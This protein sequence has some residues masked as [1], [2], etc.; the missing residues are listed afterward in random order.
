MEKDSF[1]ISKEFFSG[2]IFL[3]ILALFGASPPPLG[4]PHCDDDALPATQP[5]LIALEPRI[6]MGGTGGA[7]GVH[8][9]VRKKGFLQWKEYMKNVKVIFAFCWQNLHAWHPCDAPMPCQTI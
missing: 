1:P 3:K 5:G 4:P 8:N 6:P 2:E 7:R 9:F